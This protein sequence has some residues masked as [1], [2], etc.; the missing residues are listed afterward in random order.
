MFYRFST[1]SNTDDADQT[2]FH[3]SAR[4]R[5]IRAIRVLSHYFSL[6]RWRMQNY[7]SSIMRGMGFE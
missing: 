4:I 7:F 5:V 6:N 1:K 2:D 3:G